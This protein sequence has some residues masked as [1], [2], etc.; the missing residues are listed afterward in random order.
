MPQFFFKPY[1]AVWGLEVARSPSFYHFPCS[2]PP[3]SSILN[4]SVCV[5]WIRIPNGSWAKKQTQQC[6]NYRLLR[7]FT[8]ED[9]TLNFQ[10]WFPKY[11]H[12]MELVC[13]ADLVAPVSHSPWLKWPHCLWRSPLACINTFQHKFTWLKQPNA[14]RGQRQRHHYPSSVHCVP[15]RNSHMFDC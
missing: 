13:K 8:S 4:R 7:Y 2:T 15:L 10:S 9:R 6:C 3:Y 12:C 5:L 1:C 11:V 14:S